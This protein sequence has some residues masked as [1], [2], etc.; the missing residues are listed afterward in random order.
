VSSGT[1][2]L[3]AIIN[4]VGATGLLRAVAHGI[5]ACRDTCISIYI[6]LP[7]ALRAN[8]ASL[9]CSKSLPAIWSNTFS[10]NRENSSSLFKLVGAIGFEPTTPT[11]SRWCS[12][13]LSYAPAKVAKDTNIM[14]KL[15]VR[16][17]FSRMRSAPTGY[18][19]GVGALR[20]RDS[21]ME[22]IDWCRSASQARFRYGAYL[23]M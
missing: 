21:G 17:D 3:V 15:Q 9:R 16:S 19:I 4:L 23:L 11:M 13:Q 8:V 12:N 6:V 7:S 22:H 18:L 2:T 1:Y 5:H 10:S 20:K 14:R